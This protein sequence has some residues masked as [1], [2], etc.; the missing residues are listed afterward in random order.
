MGAEGV[1]CCRADYAKTLPFH[2]GCFDLVILH[3][4]LDHLL[5]FVRRDERDVVVDKTFAEVARVLTAGGIVAG[6]VENRFGLDNLLRGVKRAFGRSASAGGEN[7]ANTRRRLSAISCR[8]AMARAGFGDC[9]FFG[10]LPSI[11]FPKVLWSIDKGWSR[12]ASRHQ[13]RAL[14]PLVGHSSYVVWRMFAELGVSQNM[15]NA[16]FFWGRKVC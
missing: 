5:S 16:I 6:C 15:G 3:R 12:R 10:V 4:T 8:S 1:L 7:S 13:A 9:G 14:R 11:D 2:D